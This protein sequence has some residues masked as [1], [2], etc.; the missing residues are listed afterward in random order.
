MQA[1]MMLAV[2]PQFLLGTTRVWW[3]L[4]RRRKL[5][6]GAAVLSLLKFL[7]VSPGLLARFVPHF[8]KWFIPGY[9]P[10]WDGDD[11]LAIRKYDAELRAKMVTSNTHGSV[12]KLSP[13]GKADPVAAAIAVDGASNGVSNEVQQQSP[14][15]LAEIAK[16]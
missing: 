14:P 4:I 3:F 10:S 7:F 12:I 5:P 8:L 2:G 15:I 9:H 13:T 11:T 6:A 1:L 16:L